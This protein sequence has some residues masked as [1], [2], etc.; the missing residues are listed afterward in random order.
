MVIGSTRKKRR[1]SSHR[2]VGAGREVGNTSSVSGKAAATFPKGEGLKKGNGT[3]EVW[4]APSVKDVYAQLMIA[5]TMLDR[6]PDQELAVVKREM[7]LLED[8]VWQ[9]CR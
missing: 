8:M 5:K 4:Y 2:E 3:M 6:I 9:F 1:K 7:G